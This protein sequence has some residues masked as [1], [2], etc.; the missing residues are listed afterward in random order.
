MESLTKDEAHNLV[1]IDFTFFGSFVFG[2]V[3]FFEVHFK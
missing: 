3:S 2:H 1:V